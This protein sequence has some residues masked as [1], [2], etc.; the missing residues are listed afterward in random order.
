MVHRTEQA[1]QV[2]YTRYPQGG[3]RASGEWWAACKVRAKLFPIETLN[4]EDDGSNELVDI[5]YFQDDR[6]ARAQNLY[7][8][9]EAITLFDARA[10]MEE[11]NINDIHHSMD[12]LHDD[13]FIN[14]NE[15]SEI[16]EFIDEDDEILIMPT[17]GR[18]QRWGSHTNTPHQPSLAS[19]DPPSLQRSPHSPGA[20]SAI[21]LSA[22]DGQPDNWKSYC[23]D[24]KEMLC[25]DF[26]SGRRSLLLAKAIG[27]PSVIPWCTQE[28]R[29]ALG[30]TRKRW[31]H[32]KLLCQRNME[33]IVRPILQLIL[34]FGYMQLVKTK[35]GRVH[36]I[37][38]SLDIGILGST[39]A[40]SS[41]VVDLTDASTNVG[42]DVITNAV[43]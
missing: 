9:D 21:G 11:V 30:I 12:N 23:S 24:I 7:I 19:V 25:N 34:K 18:G 40:S 29:E 38:R 6:S 39:Y 36:N 31:N 1:Q 42:A 15:D 22:S 33:K 4:D 28:D 8:D 32:M 14:E 13:Q 2:Y 37:G 16:D 27:F 35:K 41:D 43:L 20:A 26:K 5:D 3:G 17:R 10:L